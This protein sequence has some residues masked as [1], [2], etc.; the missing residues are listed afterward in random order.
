MDTPYTICT[1][2]NRYSAAVSL[3]SVIKVA[4]NSIPTIY[5]E[6]GFESSYIRSIMQ[7]FSRQILT[8]LAGLRLLAELRSLA[9]LRPLPRR[10]PHVGLTSRP[11]PRL[12]PFAG[13]R[14]L[15]ELMPLPGFR[16]L[17]RRGPLPKLRPLAG[18]RPLPRL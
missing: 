5:P 17:S 15:L 10:I 16:P 18:L 12:R 2:T 7:V 3:S 14:P 8:F 1:N 9:G 6:K 11:L 13:L 4:F